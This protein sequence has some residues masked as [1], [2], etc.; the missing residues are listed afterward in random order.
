[1]A[2]KR[3]PVKKAKRSRVAK[4]KVE[5]NNLALINFKISRKDMQVIA[6]NAKKYTDCNVSAWLRYAATRFKPTVKSIRL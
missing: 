3:T 2:K 1:M 5:S 4:R 6:K